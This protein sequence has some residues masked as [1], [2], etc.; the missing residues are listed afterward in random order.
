LPENQK[1]WA[2]VVP[3]MSQRENKDPTGYRIGVAPMEEVAAKM[4]AAA[5][6]ARNYISKNKVKD[7][8]NLE[9]KEL[10]EQLNL[11]RGA[12]MIAYPAYHGL[13]DWDYVY[14]IL[15]EKIDFPAIWPDCEVTFYSS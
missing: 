8:Q 3:D 12:V 15:E 7:K 14:L 1:K 11:L 2:K 9:I 4:K 6:E 13:P 5:N 10:V